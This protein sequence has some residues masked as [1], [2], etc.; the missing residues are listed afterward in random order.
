MASSYSYT[1]VAEV[2]DP[3]SKYMQGPP[4]KD[5]KKETGGNKGKKKSYSDGGELADKEGKVQT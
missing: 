4:D 5:T 2:D 1:F 3:K